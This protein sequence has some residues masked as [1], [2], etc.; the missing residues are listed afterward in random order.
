[1]SDGSVADLPV[2]GIDTIVAE[3]TTSTARG[4]VDVE[5][6]LDPGFTVPQWERGNDIVRRQAYVAPDTLRPRFTVTVDGRSVV[7]GDYVSPRPE[8]R[9]DIGDD[10]EIPI[11]SPTLVDLR[12]DGRRVSLSTS[13]PDSSFESRWAE[14]KATA[15]LRPQFERGTHQLSVQVTDGSGNPADTTAFL[16]TFR[17]ETTSSIRDVAP[18][19]NPF[20]DATDLT[21]NF[22]GPSAP[23]EGS[24]RI[25]TI[26]GRLI[27]EI[28]IGA[29][30]VRTGFNTIHWDGRDGDGD[31]VA[32]GVYL[33]VLKLNTG[34]TW[35][36]ETAKLAKVR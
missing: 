35:L 20:A 23:D 24:I 8:I 28:T 16:L 12:L 14:K 1:V 6:A 7:N 15:I 30:Q 3:L 31:T 29:G 21:F 36:Q 5:V 19:P 4:R 10:G 18:Y 34:G 33:A 2:G 27:R 13:T 25:Y 22:T 17:V 11:A 26:A 32:N 9:V